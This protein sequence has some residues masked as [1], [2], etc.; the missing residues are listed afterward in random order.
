MKSLL[1]ESSRIEVNQGYT[2]YWYHSATMTG[3]KRYYLHV[4]SSGDVTTT[5]SIWNSRIQDLNFY[6]SSSKLFIV[7]MM[8]NLK[9]PKK[10]KQTSTSN[11]QTSKPTNTTQ[12]GQSLL[13]SKRKSNQSIT[14]ATTVIG[15]TKNGIV[16]IFS[17]NRFYVVV[18]PGTGKVSVTKNA[19]QATKFGKY[20]YTAKFRYL[21]NLN[22]TL[23]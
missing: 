3:S 16:K 23:L 21:I 20:C 11:K 12:T 14:N 22:F 18:I 7:T 8:N 5:T 15:R 1:E 4:S 9:I 13:H 2:I 6:V 19:T 17:A 10:N